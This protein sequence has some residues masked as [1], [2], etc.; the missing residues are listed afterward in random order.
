MY[1]AR[2]LSSWQHMRLALNFGV[3]GLLIFLLAGCASPFGMGSSWAYNPVTNTC[4]RAS[5]GLSEEECRLRIETAA[6]ALVA[7]TRIRMRS[8]LSYGRS[9]QQVEDALRSRGTFSLPSRGKY[10]E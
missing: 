3:A 5:F 8:R 2:T 1:D 7:A 6:T 9:R 10:D 4:E